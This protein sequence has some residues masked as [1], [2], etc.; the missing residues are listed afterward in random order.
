MRAR[1]GPTDYKI[2]DLIEVKLRRPQGDSIFYPA[3]VIDRSRTY[4][5]VRVVGSGSEISLTRWDVRLFV[6][7]PGEIYGADALDAEATPIEESTVTTKEPIRL[8]FSAPTPVPT[9]VTAPPVPPQQCAAC[10]QRIAPKPQPPSIGTEVLLVKCGH[11]IAFDLFAK[12]PFRDGRRQKAVGRD[13]PACRLGR[14]QAEVIAATAKKTA[15]RRA[16]ASAAQARN[17][18]RPRLP[19][20]ACITAT[21]N[22]AEVR[23]TGSLA[24]VGGETYARSADSIKKLLGKLDDA[25]REHL[26]LHAELIASI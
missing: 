6:R 21:Y 10:P 11:T 23:W 20:G 16:A 22:A 19:D 24:I 18:A 14:V 3:R 12:D 2:D 8:K 25:Y 15:K 1:P 5:R 26:K 7:R 9:I 4:L 17:A 13:C